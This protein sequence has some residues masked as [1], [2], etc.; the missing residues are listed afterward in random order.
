MRAGD[1]A[2]QSLPVEAQ[3]QQT[4]PEQPQPTPER[5]AATNEQEAVRRAL[6]QHPE[7]LDAFRTLEYQSSERANAA[8]KRY[9]DA[10]Q[11]AAQ[12]HGNA[13]QQNAIAATV[14]LVSQFPELHNLTAEQAPVAIKTVAQSNPERA[15][16]MVRH[17]EQSRY[18]C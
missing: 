18:D 9:A 13:V 1:A 17:R 11:Q 16:N 6:E 3:P 4:I 15:Q 14:A 2:Q 7:L 10:A 12:Q 5:P 8:E